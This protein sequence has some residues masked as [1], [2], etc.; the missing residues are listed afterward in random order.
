MAGRRI[1]GPP[2]T[3]EW[4]D[5]LIKHGIMA[6]PEYVPT[7]DELAVAHAA[8][9]AA[10]DPLAGKSLDELDE[11]EDDYDDT[12]LKM[13]RYVKER[14]NL[15]TQLCRYSQSVLLLAEKNDL[16]KWPAALPKPNSV[17][18]CIL[19]KPILFVKSVRHPMS[20]MLLSTCIKTGSVF[21]FC[22]N[23]YYY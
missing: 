12:V 7:E 1:D 4:E 2:Q 19:A 20:V 8:K 3:T 13:Y 15:Q 18:C 6:A 11:L 21:C 16:L 22:C 5:A 14:K 10:V 23:Y 17:P 9:L